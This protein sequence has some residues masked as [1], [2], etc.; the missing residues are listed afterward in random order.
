VHSFVE[1]NPLAGRGGGG[2]VVRGGG[3]VIEGGWG[4]DKINKICMIIK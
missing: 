3:V 4:I 2:V 1:Y